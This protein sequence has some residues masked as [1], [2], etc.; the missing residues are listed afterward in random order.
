MSSQNPDI[1]HR[2]ERTSLPVLA[3]LSV[4]AFVGCEQAGE[5]STAP[6]TSSIGT[7]RFT[8]GSG[9]TATLL[10]LGRLDA[11]HVH[12]NFGT[13][14]VELKT[15]DSADVRV[16]SGTIEPGG[17]NGWHSHPG[18][19]VVVV[20]AGTLTLFDADC[21]P[22]V[23][24]TGTAFTEQAEHVH[25]AM[26]LGTI[27]AQFIAAFITPRGAAPRIDAPDPGNCS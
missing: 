7:P 12:T 14:R 1:V 16:N 2:A 19:G 17:Y 9:A 27:P 10:A 25:I 22:S 15:S 4:L 5:R 20:T 3:A 26:N 18:L 24:P 13:F 23:Y 6:S 8:V 11:L 21:M